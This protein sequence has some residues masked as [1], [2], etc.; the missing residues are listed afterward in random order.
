LQGKALNGT[1]NHKEVFQGMLYKDCTLKR[2][3]KR[4]EPVVTTLCTLE[5]AVHA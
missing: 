1:L 4:A 3:C 2:A 5:R